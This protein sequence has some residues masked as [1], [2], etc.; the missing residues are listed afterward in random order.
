MALKFSSEAVF[1]I[2]RPC[3]HAK[4]FQVY[5]I[6]TLSF[7]YCLLKLVQTAAFEAPPAHQLHWNLPESTTFYA[8]WL[9]TPDSFSVK[10]TLEMPQGRSPASRPDGSPTLYLPP[11]HP[12]SLC[13]S[14]DTPSC[15]LC[16]AAPSCQQFKSGLHRF[17]RQHSCA[18][19]VRV[20]RWW[21][22][23]QQG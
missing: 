23:Q 11:H 20:K 21:W 18:D 19:V 4:H 7:F 12:L 13:Q 8:R 9:P 17:S 22:H 1:N 6:V 5:Y 10:E 16:W 15:H 2:N 14:P 3:Y